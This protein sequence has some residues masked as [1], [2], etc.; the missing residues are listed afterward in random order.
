MSDRAERTIQFAYASKSEAS[1]AGRTAN[2]PAARERLCLPVHPGRCPALRA[3]GIAIIALVAA[4]AA[5]LVS[6]Q[7]QFTGIYGFGYSYA[8][9]AAG[10]GAGIG[11]AVAEAV[12]PGELRLGRG[13]RR[14]ECRHQCYDRDPGRPERGAPSRVNWPAQSL[15]G[16]GFVRRAPGAARFGF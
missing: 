14:R 3:A 7:A 8:D 2:E 11:I 5:T 9:T 4:L 13:E 10:P 16:R 12:N 15:P 6:A 1:G